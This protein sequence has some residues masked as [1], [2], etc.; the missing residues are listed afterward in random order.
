MAS[1]EMSRSEHPRPPDSLLTDRRRFHEQV[2]RTSAQSALGASDHGLTE[3]DVVVPSE[4][5]EQLDCAAAFFK[6]D[7]PICRIVRG[8]SE[9]FG[10]LFGS[11]AEFCGGHNVD[12]RA[13]E[14]AWREDQPVR[15]P[16]TARSWMGP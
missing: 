16:R 3:Q 6:P 10:F 8:R 12:G 2:P 15:I 13:A 9:F 11:G 1:T 5:G 4:R 14:P 7:R